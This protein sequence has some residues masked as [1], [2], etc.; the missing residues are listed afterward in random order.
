MIK[1]YK[2]YLNCYRFLF[3]FSI[4]IN[5]LFLYNIILFDNIENLF[6]T[7]LL[8]ISI[9]ITIF[10][11]LYLYLTKNKKHFTIIYIIFIIYIIILIIISYNL[12]SIYIKINKISINKTLY[13]SSIVTLKDN[14]N[15][16]IMNIDKIGIISNK[17]YIDGYI[18][19]LEI[20]DNNNLDVELV[21]YSDYISMINDLLN[22]KIEY[23]FLPT[24]YKTRFDDIN[25]DK[26]KIIYS[27]R[28]E[29]KYE[30]DNKKDLESFTILLMGVDST[31]NNIDNSFYNGDALI[32]ITFNPKKNTSTMLSI[33][34]DTYL[35]I[36]CMNDRRNKITH[37]AWFD[38]DCIIST[39]NNSFNIN[40]NYYI[41]IN[42]KGLVN[43]V[44]NLGGIVVDVPYS[45][46]ESNSN[47]LWGMNTIYVEKGIQ[48]LDGEQALAF[49]RNR[50]PWP[51][52]CGDKWTNYYSNDIIRGENQKK[53][54]K[55]I[56]EKVKT[57][58]SFE[59]FRQI[60]DTISENILTNINT[61]NILSFYK[62][63]KNINNINIQKLFLNGY[64]EYIY[65]YDFINNTGTNLTLYNYIPYKESIDELSK[66]MNDNL[67]GK[68]II[69]NETIG[70]LEGTKYID[71]MPSF[72]GKTYY[73]AQEFC[74]QHNIKLIINYVSGTDIGYITNQSINE[75]T[76]LDYVDTLTIDVVNNIELE[77]E[78]SKIDT[79][80]NSSNNKIEKNT[81]ENNI[82]YD[83]DPIIKEIFN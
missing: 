8:T 83:L 10:F 64:D 21:Y 67:D 65:D 62:M 23:I 27:Q 14:Y 31:D 46:C 24:N 70:D 58:K 29:I 79:S 50:H 60:L 33:P 36:S 34:R 28:K 41:K 25:V 44:D 82:N 35:N 49:A 63:G 53:V 5:F 1:Q 59:S 72:I 39:I 3:I 80:N 20:I 11:N 71:I 37:S 12:K 19:P 16:D 66:V 55:S 61:N 9:L 26:L 4:I 22:K 56:V 43:L 48:Q 6:R 17:K 73:E 15:E 81:G 42:F 74:D 57:I 75:L 54:I 18:I 78:I 38:D 7:I 77:K 51:E 69:T 68:L 40:I 52:F 2:I 30:I 32:L 76:D 13:S 47:R 45:F